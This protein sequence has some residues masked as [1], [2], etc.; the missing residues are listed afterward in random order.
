MVFDYD[1]LEAHNIIIEYKTLSKKSQFCESYI[2][3]I[4]LDLA[5]E[6]TRK[7]S[8]NSAEILNTDV[9]EE[10]YFNFLPNSQLFSALAIEL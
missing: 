8:L 2:F 7:D 1:K 10:H 9:S 6:T 3:D 5:L 4:V